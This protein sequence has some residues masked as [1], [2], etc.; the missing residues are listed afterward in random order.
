[1]VLRGSAIFPSCFTLA[2]PQH[3]YPTQVADVNFAT[4]W[5]KSKAATIA[6]NSSISLPGIVNILV[7]NSTVS[8][9]A[10]RLAE[11]FQTRSR[12]LILRSRVNG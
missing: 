9:S 11:W 2:A 4:R 3:P 10:P 8:R 5:L 6:R 1:M 7:H 12:R